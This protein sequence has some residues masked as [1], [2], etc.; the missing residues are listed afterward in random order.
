M[1]FAL[2]HGTMRVIVHI[3]AMDEDR[4]TQKAAKQRR[5]HYGK[6]KFCHAT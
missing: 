1:H 2:T 4:L 5:Y 3:H 6:E